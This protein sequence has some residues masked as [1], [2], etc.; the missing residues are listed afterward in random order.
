[1]TRRSQTDDQQ[2]SLFLWEGA[3]LYLGQI[4][5]T[6]PHAHHAMQICYGLDGEFRLL[7]GKE[8]RRTG[9]ALIPPDFPHQ[10]T[11]G[12][13]RLALALVDGDTMQKV[14]AQPVTAPAGKKPDLFLQNI[15]QTMA[16]AKALLKELA[17]PAATPMKPATPP[18]LRIQRVLTHLKTPLPQRISAREM[19]SLANLSESRFLHL[20]SKNTGLPLRRYILWRRLITAIQAITEGNDLTGAAH[21]GGFSD[22]AHFTRTFRQ[23][24]GLSPSRLFKSSRNV[25]VFLPPV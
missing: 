5:D 6:T 4:S 25:Q 17:S 20:F 22:S 10:L 9:F 21:L 13:T 12:S 1:M 7:V 3:A 23:T 24:F 15:P 11:G 8:D 19:A 18:D 16:E 14:P 2:A